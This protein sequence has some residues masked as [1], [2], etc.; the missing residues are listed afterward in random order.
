[1]S[2]NWGKKKAKKKKKKPTMEQTNQNFGFD[3]NKWKFSSKSCH[4]EQA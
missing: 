4:P 2:H 3:E 1:M